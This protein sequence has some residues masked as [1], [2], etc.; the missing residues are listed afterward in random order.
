V[1]DDPRDIFDRAFK[2][3]MHLSNSAVI[4]FINGSFDTNYP[5]DSTVEHPSTE[6]VTDELKRRICDIII[7]I[8]NDAYLIEAQI[9]D[10]GN[11]A[12]R[13]F[14]YGYQYALMT[15]TIDNDGAIVLELPRPQVMYWEATK[16]TPDS[17][18]VRIKLPDGAHL[19]YNVTSFKPLE[20]S[21]AE[22]G[23]RKMSI[24]LP[25]FMIKPR[26]QVLTAKSSKERKQIAEDLKSLVRDLE[27]MTEQSVLNGNMTKAD[28][29][30]VINIMKRLYDH[31]YKK[32]DDF[33]EVQIMVDDIYWTDADKM[34]REA[35][36]ARKATWQE[37]NEAMKKDHIEIAQSLINDGFTPELVAKYSKLDLSTVK[38]LY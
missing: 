9:D 17:E 23:A 12:L 16:K 20:H 7:V 19:D 14:N 22:I 1:V 2:R 26:K 18:T 4:N 11:M 25:F 33:T 8:Q 21:I 27:Y 13:I 38:S 37:A 24:L 35:E 31:L 5:L 10:D 34:M 28:K 29:S 15:K 36:E 30:I 6:S 32:Y 3:L